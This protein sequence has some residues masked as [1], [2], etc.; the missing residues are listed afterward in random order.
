MLK[1]I[2]LDKYVEAYVSF[3]SSPAPLGVIMSAA[4]A[5][6]PKIEIETNDEFIEIIF[7]DGSSVS[8]AREGA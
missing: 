4:L 1:A 8:F 6:D 3:I 5:M 7:S 2:R